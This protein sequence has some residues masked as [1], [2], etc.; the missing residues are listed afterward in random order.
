MVLN[1]MGQNRSKIQISMSIQINLGIF[2]VLVEN[3]GANLAVR[4]VFVSPSR[5]EPR[6]RYPTKLSDSSWLGP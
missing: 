1:F 3:T 2:K 6:L 5:L 4:F